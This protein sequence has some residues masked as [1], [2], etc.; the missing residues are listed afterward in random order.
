MLETLKEM[1]EFLNFHQISKVKARRHEQPKKIY[2][3]QG[4]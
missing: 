3:K 4:Y 1:Y 2:N